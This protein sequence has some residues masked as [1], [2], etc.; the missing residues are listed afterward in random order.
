MRNASSASE[1]GES[2]NNWLEK[3]S[4]LH[5][6]AVTIVPPVFGSADGDGE[7]RIDSDHGFIG[8]EKAGCVKNG[9]WQVRDTNPLDLNDFFVGNWQTVMND[10]PLVESETMF[11]GSE[12]SE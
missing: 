9:R 5:S 4:C 3:V 2:L 6:E 1:P 12:E 10:A 7:E 11:M 8:P